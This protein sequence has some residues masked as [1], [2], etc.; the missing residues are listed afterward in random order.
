MDKLKELKNALLDI[1]PFMNEEFYNNYNNF[2]FERIFS[3][4]LNNIIE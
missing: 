2:E 4:K 3:I 1:L